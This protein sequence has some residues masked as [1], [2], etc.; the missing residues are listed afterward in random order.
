MKIISEDTK[1]LI[2]RLQESVG[3]SENRLKIIK[4]INKKESI[5]ELAKRLKISQPTMSK[6]ISRFES[7]KL[8]LFLHKGGN[9]EVYDKV[10]LLKTINID[11][12]IKL[13]IEIEKHKESIIKKK[14][15]ISSGIPFLTS[16]DEEDAE[17]MMKPYAIIYKIEN[18]LRNLI[19]SKLTNTY[20]KEWW[21]DIITSKSILDKVKGRK[22]LEGKHKWHVK[23]GRGAHNIFYTDLDD[24]RYIIVNKE[25]DKVFK[26]I[27]PSKT[28]IE[29]LFEVLGLSRNIIDHHNALPTREIKRLEEILED[30]KRQFKGDSI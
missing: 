24:L 23:R 17:N 3:T 25:W 29:N 21:K 1:D 18:A 20:G 30:W 22:D 26:D 13:K 15:K 5:A 14:V 2:K 6:A 28:W 11:S 19:I 8:I 4:N 16:E 10:P 12:A 7:R 9:S 27:F